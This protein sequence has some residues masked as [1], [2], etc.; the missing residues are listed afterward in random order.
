MCALPIFREAKPIYE[1]PLRA[2]FPIAALPV[3]GLI[4]GII[5]TWRARANDN[6]VGW[7]AVPLFSG[8]AT[9]MLMWQVRAGP[10]APLL[11][12][13]GVTALAW[14]ILPGFRRQRS[15]RGR[16]GGPGGGF[17]LVSGF[18][19]SRRCQLPDRE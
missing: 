4:G 10:A 5:A 13:P 15:V 11:A 6:V 7:V 9:A 19:A 14:L 1:H 12:V 2:A 8:F 17:L 16:V 18:F 3:I